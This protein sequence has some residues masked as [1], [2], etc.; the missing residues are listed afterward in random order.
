[1]FPKHYRLSRAEVSLVI[2]KGV[3]SNTPFFSIKTLDL[4]GKNAKSAFVVSKKEC[5]LSVDRNQLRR[6]VRSVFR[7]V[8]PEL[9]RHLGIVIFIKKQ[10]K[11]A[12][13][14]QILSAF[15]TVFKL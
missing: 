8:Y 11:E 12:G 13:F 7:E 15:K 14:D 4:Q 5:R 1:M 2:K 10:A 6:K 3:A 9:P